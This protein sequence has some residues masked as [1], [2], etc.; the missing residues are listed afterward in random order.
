MEPSA[1]C[2]QLGHLEMGIFICSGRAACGKEG[3]EV[4]GALCHAYHWLYLK[5]GSTSQAPTPKDFSLQMLRPGAATHWPWTAPG[6]CHGPPG[7]AH[8]PL[9]GPRQGSLRPREVTASL[10]AP[11]FY[12][13][14]L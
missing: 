13:V 1:H 5:C 8:L 14:V 11:D 4:M 7:P 10:Q 3:S 9:R 12:F 6:G 2:G